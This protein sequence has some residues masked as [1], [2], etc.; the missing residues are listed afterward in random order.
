[1]TLGFTLDTPPA[2]GARQQREHL[3][4]GVFYGALSIMI[5]MSLIFAIALKQRNAAYYAVFL[6]STILFW[7]KLNGIGF[8]Y[9]WPDAVW[10][11]NEGFHIV[12]LLFVGCAL[13]F[14]KSFLQLDSLA[15]RLNRVFATL[16]LLALAGIVARLLGLYEPVLMLSFALLVVLTF[17]IPFASYKVWRDGLDYAFWSLLAWLLYAVGLLLSIIS[18]STSLFSWGMTPLFYAQVAS[19]LETLF[20][21]IGLSKW[22]IQLELERQKAISQANE[23]ALTG[24]GNRR[25][26]QLAFTQLKDAMVIDHRPAFVLMID[27]DYFKQINDTFGHDAGDKVLTEVGSLLLR[28]CRE[29]DVVTRYGGEEFAILLRAQDVDTVVQVAERIRVEFASSPTKH[30]DHMIEHTLCCGIAEIMN[31]DQQPSVQEMMKHADE[32]LYQAKAAGRNQ[33]HVYAH[34]QPHHIV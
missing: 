19:L 27:L 20:L 29:S 32:A 28:I 8:Q 26:L 30:H 1:M 10:W 17:V 22:L 23:D 21:M 15:P 5:I 12:Y 34:K 18:A 2:F 4:F 14:S 16:Q 7:L 13:Q 33:S 24:L 9:L 11:H 6:L 3:G 31:I 25:R